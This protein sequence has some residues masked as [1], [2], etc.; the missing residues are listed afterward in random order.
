[1]TLGLCHE[2]GRARRQRCTVATLGDT[3]PCLSKTW[4][5]VCLVHPMTPHLFPLI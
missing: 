1:M 3:G 5:T 2:Q 4:R